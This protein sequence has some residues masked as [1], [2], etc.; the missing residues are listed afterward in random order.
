MIPR[1]PIS[2]RTD[3]LLPY[4]TLFRSGLLR[5]VPA[6]GVVEGEDRIDVLAVGQEGAGGLVLEV[7][8]PEAVAELVHHHVEEAD[9]SGGGVAVE[10]VVEVE[11]GTEPRVDVDE[12]GLQVGAR[13]RIGQRRAVPGVGDRKSTRLN[14][15]H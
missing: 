14:S 13:D 3:T 6:G 7:L 5:P 9:L 8:E 11:V 15:S 1:P 2:T 10:A 4:T 12:A